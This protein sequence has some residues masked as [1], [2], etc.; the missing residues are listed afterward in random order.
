MVNGWNRLFKRLILLQQRLIER[1]ED[2]DGSQ[3]VINEFLE[4][5]KQAG[6]AD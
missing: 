2:L 3:I 6:E 5:F 4:R 1:G